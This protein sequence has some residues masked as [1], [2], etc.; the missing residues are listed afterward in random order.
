VIGIAY[1]ATLVVLELTIGLVLIYSGATGLCSREGKFDAESTKLMQVSF[2][3]GLLAGFF[4]LAV[5]AGLVRVPYLVGLR[6]WR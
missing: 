3:V 5:V 4:L 1:N 6:L 2:V